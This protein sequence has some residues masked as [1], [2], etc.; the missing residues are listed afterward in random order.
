LISYLKL[1]EV[2]ATKE[3][4]EAGDKVCIDDML[5]RG[6]F[7]LGEQSSEADCSKDNVCGVLIKDETH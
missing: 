1:G 7:L 3:L 4:D 2:N 5:N 6:V